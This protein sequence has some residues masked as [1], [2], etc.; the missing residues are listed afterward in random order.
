MEILDT[1]KLS[2]EKLVAISKLIKGINPSV[3]KTLVKVSKVL[4]LIEQV[5]KGEVMDLTLQNLPAKTAEEKKRKKTVLLLL[6]WWRQLRGEIKR[7]RQEI[8]QIKQ[9]DQKI[10][11]VEG[12]G[13]ILAKAKGPVGIITVMA[14]GIVGVSILLGKNK[15]EPVAR[16]VNRQTIQVIVVGEKRIPTT[17]VKTATGPECDGEHYHAKDG[18]A[19]KATDGTMVDDPGGCGLGKVSEVRVEEVEI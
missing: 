10:R 8:E 14:I 9:T 4:K 3:D 5:Q 11:Q 1:D 15:P 18:V 16:E 19:A 2:R 12:G 7:V 6:K 17:E 13:R